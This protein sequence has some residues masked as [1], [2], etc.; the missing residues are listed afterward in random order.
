MYTLV[1]DTTAAGCGVC[2]QKDGNIIDKIEKEMDFGQA[3]ELLPAIKDILDKNKIMMTDLTAIA[4]CTG[5]GSFTGVRACISAARTFSF[6]LPECKVYGISAFDAYINNLEP[7]EIADVNAVI[8]ETKRSDFYCQIYD[9]AKNKISEPLAAHYEEIISRLK[10]SGKKISLIGDGVER[11]LSKP[12]GLSL[13]AIKMTRGLPIDSLAM[14][15]WQKYCN[16]I[17][18]FPKPLYIKAP[19]LGPK[20][21]LDN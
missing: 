14:A 8:I 9:S 2:L 20:K 21:T 6:A 3:E 11:F 15:A 5:P 18:D 1:F 12:S 10:N 19:D 13:H 7:Q 16:K 17:F 4:V